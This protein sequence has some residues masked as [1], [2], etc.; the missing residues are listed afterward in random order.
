MKQRAAPA[1]VA[2]MALLAFAL[3]ASYEFARSPTESLFLQVYSSKDL[4]Y[5]WL[6]V[7][8]AA[9]LATAVYGRV[10]QKLHL[11]P[12][13]GWSALTFLALL[14]MILGLE[15]LGGPSVQPYTRFALYLWKDV[16]I[17]VLIEIFWSLAN[18][19]FQIRTAKWLY[20]LFCVA[21][22]SGG[23]AANSLVPSLTQA[24]GTYAVLAVLFPLLGIVAIG[25][26][27]APKPDLSQG[28]SQSAPQSKEEAEKPKASFSV[29]RQSPYLMLM[30][31]L[32]GSIQVVITLIDY[33][34]NGVLERSYPDLDTRT[35]VISKVYLTINIGSVALQLLTGPVLKLLGISKTLVSIPLLLGGTLIGYVAFPAFALLAA[36]KVLSKVLDY[37]LFRASKEILYIPLSYTEKTQGKAMVDMLTYRVAKG[38]ASALLLVLAGA[39]NLIWALIGG[40]IAVW[41][42]LSVLIGRRYQTRSAA[43]E[44]E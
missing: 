7:G 34:F 10:S 18:T 39:G 24:V 26:L 42:G 38:G 11:L 31:M 1:S 5:A 25:C 36:T 12:L 33:Q 8:L 14:G 9:A 27:L 22:S 17:V 19:M 3:I 30:L 35:Q 2:M 21:G 16:Y 40:L 15:Q 37:S 43:Q 4:P 20:G 41:A 23:A 32:I 13:L 44:T 28:G 6:G 29:L